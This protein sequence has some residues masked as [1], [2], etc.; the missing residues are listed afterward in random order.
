MSRHDKTLLRI[1]TDPI[2]KNINYSDVAALFKSL[3]Y[4]LSNKG[5]TSGSRVEFIGK[6]TEVSF[7]KPHPEKELKSYV[8][9]IIRAFLEVEGVIEKEGDKWAT[10]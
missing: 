4:K 3:D 2:L 6:V 1:C 5:R 7:H 8:I 9:K 10:T